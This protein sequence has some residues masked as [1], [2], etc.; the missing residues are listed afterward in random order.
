MF[1]FCFENLGLLLTNEISLIHFFIF[2]Y[3]IISL[4]RSLL[5]GEGLD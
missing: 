5:I 1:V 3:A 2:H 4:T